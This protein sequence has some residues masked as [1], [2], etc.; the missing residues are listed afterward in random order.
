VHLGAVGGLDAFTLNALRRCPDLALRLQRDAC[1]SRLRWSIRASMSSSA[2]RSLASSAQ[3]SRQ[4]STIWVA[5]QSRTFA[6]KPF[7][8]TERI[9]SMT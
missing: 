5:F 7:S 3:R 1:A 9:V 8:S 4:R 2:R 6:P